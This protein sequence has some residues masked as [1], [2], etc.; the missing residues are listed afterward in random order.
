MLK[1]FPEDFSEVLFNPRKGLSRVAKNNSLWHGL[2]VY[3][4]VALVV[5]LSSIHLS[6]QV[7]GLLDLPPD[8][9]SMVRME[10]L[11]ALS[12]AFP[13]LTVLLHIV[14][15]P[16]LFL[17]GVAVLNFVATLFGGTGSAYK[18]G[19]VLGYAQLPYLVVALG[20]LISR[21]T[22]ID[23]MGIFVLGAFLW[24]LLLK[25]YGLKVV[26]GFSSARALLVYF[27][28]LIAL[29]VAVILFLLLAIVFVIP[30]LIQALESITD[31]PPL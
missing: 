4:M 17:L 20:G 26:H 6:Q 5:S 8:L 22:V 18:L 30:F 12:R 31:V 13:I 21:Y 9:A 15:G 1:S 10:L 28:P 14:F 16:L 27:M 11:E 24:S 7:N 23:L 2:L 29:L 25:V 19:A 3:L